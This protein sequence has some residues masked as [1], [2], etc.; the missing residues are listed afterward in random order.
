[1]AKIVISKHELVHIFKESLTESV[2]ECS[3]YMCKNHAKF[4]M[5][6]YN[7]FNALK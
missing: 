1:M 2:L 5:Y 6:S 4:K 3:Q 7:F